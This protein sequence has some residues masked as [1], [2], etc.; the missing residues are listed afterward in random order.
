MREKLSDGKIIIRRY[1]RED[2]DDQ[3]EAAI[4]SRNDVFPYLPW[5]H[6]KYSRK[7][8]ETWIRMQDR[9]WNEKKEFKFA[10]VY[11]KTDRYLCGTGINNINTVYKFANLGYWIRTSAV[12][13]GVATAAAMLTAR[14]GFEDLKLNRLEIVVHPD[15]IASRH[16][17][18][19]IGAVLEGTLRNR[20]AMHGEVFDAVCFSLIPEDPGFRT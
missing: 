1:K 14:F 13:K 19:N 10:I 8:S 20:L 5:C 9:L 17:A 6:P 4:E 11:K 2:I 16:V 12:R 18:K 3:Y 15:N 7:D